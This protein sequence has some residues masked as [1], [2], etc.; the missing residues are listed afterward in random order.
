MSAVLLSNDDTFK[1]AKVASLMCPIHVTYVTNCISHG[2]YD[3]YITHTG[4]HA[5]FN[6]I[7]DNSRRT[8]AVL[9]PASVYRSESDLPS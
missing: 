4:L 8:G 3:S 6:M 1:I 7:R 5:V 9:S 2:H